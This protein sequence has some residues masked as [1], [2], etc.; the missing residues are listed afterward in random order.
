VRRTISTKAKEDGVAE[1]TFVGAQ[2]G[3]DVVGVSVGDCVGDDVVGV[4][5]GDCVGDDVVGVLVGDCV[6][7]DVVGVLVG[8]CVGLT[9]H[10]QSLLSS[11]NDADC[12]MPP[13]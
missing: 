13:T 10:V 12:V 8:D 2:A 7:D 9:M 4:S 1:R 3:D 5:V 6:G 11:V